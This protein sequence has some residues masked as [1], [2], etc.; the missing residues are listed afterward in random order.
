VRVTQI[1]FY[2]D[3]ERRY[4]EELLDDWPT[5]STIAYA[6]KTAGV[7]VSVIQANKI[8]GRVERSGI[9]YE[10]LSPGRVRRTLTKT[11]KFRELITEL[12]PDVFHVH[13]LGFAREVIE[14]HALFPTVPILLQDHADP[15]PRLWRRGKWRRA[16]RAA[17]GVSFCARDQAEPLIRA[18]VLDPDKAVFE[19][20]E[21]TSSFEPGKRSAARA[22]TGV[23]G[24]PAILW[25]GRL[26]ANKDP[27]TVLEGMAAAIPDLPD[28]QLWCCF[29]SSPLLSRVK[30]RVDTDPALRGRVHLLGAVPHREVEV[31]MR[32]ADLFVLGSHSEG[33]SFA[34]IEALATGL[35][36]VATDIPSTSALTG[37]GEVGALWKKGD[38]RDLGRAIIRACADLDDSAR[39]R[40]RRY[41]NEHLSEE[42]LGRRFSD[43]YRCL[44]G[45]T[46]SALA[47]E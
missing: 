4:P 38:A 37:Y 13:G 11:E 12:H 21:S 20:P 39:I 44:A 31:L 26:N 5:L 43:V 32:A 2:V 8:A 3:P 25:V 1:S 22:Q 19:L 7:A 15:V 18:G 35:T 6:I 24:E 28:L 17:T 45:S 14:L 46:Q 34:L 23:Y 29:G 41:F 30:R 27:L 47:Q 9:V 33:G 40:V 16:I 10:F 36:P 42:A